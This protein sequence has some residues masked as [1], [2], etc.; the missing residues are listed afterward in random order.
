MRVRVCSWL[1]DR[2]DGGATMVEYALMVA[3]IAMVCLAAVH[4]LGGETGAS[5][6]RS[7]DSMFLP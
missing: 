1:D 5:L 4:L 2:T 7:Y 6:S 3:L